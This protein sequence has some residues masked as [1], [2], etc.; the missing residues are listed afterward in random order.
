MKHPS[1]SAVYQPHPLNPPLLQKERGNLIKKRGFAPLK[2]PKILEEFRGGWCPL[3]LLPPL[4]LIKG[5][6]IKGIGLPI[7]I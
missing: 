3:F 7:N 4:P 5:K 6:G 1:Y 2:H